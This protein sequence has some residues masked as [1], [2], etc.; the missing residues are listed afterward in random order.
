MPLL[1]HGRIPAYNTQVRLPSRAGSGSFIM[2]PVR[3]GT[4]DIGFVHSQSS[5]TK[6]IVVISRLGKR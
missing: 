5:R 6:D 4:F 2:P 1:E 3:G